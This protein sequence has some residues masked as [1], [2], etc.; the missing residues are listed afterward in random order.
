MSVVSGYRCAPL[1]VAALVDSWTDT[2]VYPVPVDTRQSVCVILFL[3][4]LTQICQAYQQ[5]IEELEG[6]KWD[7]EQE[8][9]VKDA[10]VGSRD[11]PQL[12][13]SRGA[14]PPLH[15]TAGA[16]GSRGLGCSGLRGAVTCTVA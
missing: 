10:Q 11:A 16:T 2:C 3:A 5:K 9:E 8:V 15:R 7:L 1:A 14:L 4:E 13:S 6:S 12:L